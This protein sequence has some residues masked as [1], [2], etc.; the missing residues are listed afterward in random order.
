MIQT[1]IVSELIRF[2]CVSS[3]FSSRS[4]FFFF[5]KCS[6]ILN[7]SKSKYNFLLLYE[8]KKKRFICIISVVVANRNLLK[9][10]DA[11]PL[12]FVRVVDPFLIIYFFLL[13]LY[14]IWL[15]EL[16]LANIANNLRSRRLRLSKP[17]IFY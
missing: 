6:T 3:F 2:L 10:A 14:K 16:K 7:Q 11:H 1:K 8:L 12:N 15:N 17:E 9:F 4:F 13:N 5:L